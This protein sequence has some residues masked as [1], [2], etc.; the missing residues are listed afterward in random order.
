MIPKRF[1]VVF[2]VFDLRRACHAG[3]KVATHLRPEV[4]RDPPQ[5]R[6]RFSGEC[7]KRGKER[8]RVVAV[9][10]EMPDVIDERRQIVPF[11]RRSSRL[12]GAVHIP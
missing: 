12:G 11:R 9:L 8:S 10:H 6:A 2:A 4:I 5:F 1:D 3:L 7:S